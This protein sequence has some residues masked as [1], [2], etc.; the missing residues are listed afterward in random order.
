MRSL[1]LIF[2]GNEEVLPVLEMAFE[3]VWAQLETEK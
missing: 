1:R 2:K 3:S